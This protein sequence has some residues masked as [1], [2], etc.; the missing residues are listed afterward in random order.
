MIKR[1]IQIHNTGLVLC[2]F[3]HL[4]MQSN[5][6]V[7]N[8][9][10]LFILNFKQHRKKCKVWFLNCGNNHVSKALKRALSSG[11]ADIGYVHQHR[12]LFEEQFC[13]VAFILEIQLQVQI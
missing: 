1:I 7:T 12:G 9:V 3:F 2:I 4:V 8:A 6:I 11:R 13:E 10:R 5:M